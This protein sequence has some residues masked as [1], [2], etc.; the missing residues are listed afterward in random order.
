MVGLMAQDVREL[1]R[2]NKQ[3]KARKK[4]AKARRPARKNRHSLS[5]SVTLVDSNQS[6][7]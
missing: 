3:E 1:R 5:D 4:E 2:L 6:R 7:S